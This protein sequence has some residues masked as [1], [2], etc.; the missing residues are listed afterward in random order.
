M[1][2]IVIEH[3]SLPS[4]DLTELET[5][6]LLDSFEMEFTRTYEPKRNAN[7]QTVFQRGVDPVVNLSASGRISG[8]SRT[9]FA[10]QHPGT[11][12]TALTNYSTTIRGF[13]PGVGKIIFNDVT[14][15]LN[16]TDSTPTFSFSATHFPGM[17]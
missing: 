6:I 15:T 1:A 16:N 14:D 11:T 7:K 13:A 8:T 9:G 2:T 10:A 17:T 3:G 12:I 5:G 4:Y